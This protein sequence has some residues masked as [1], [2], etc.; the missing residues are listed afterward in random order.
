MIKFVAKLN[1]DPNIHMKVETDSSYRIWKH[2]NLINREL[3]DQ[4]P[5][6]AITGLQEAL[7][8]ADTFVFEQAIASDT[9]E[10][11]H[12]L[13]KH[14]SVT[15]VDSAGTVFFAAVQYVDNNNIIITMNGATTGKAYL[16]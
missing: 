9:W 16:N 11:C 5:I 10:I 2:D 1:K 6:E 12:N 14:P 13:E 15:V 3:P 8:R 4:H 7:L